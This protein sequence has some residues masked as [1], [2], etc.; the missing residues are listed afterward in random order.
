MKKV[1]SLAFSASLALSILLLP[2][3]N[4]YAADE[5][6]PSYSVSDNSYQEM[7]AAGMTDSD[8]ELLRKH[9][10]NDLRI[11]KNGELEEKALNDQKTSQSLTDSLENPRLAASSLGTVGDILVAYNASSWGIDFG[12]PGH[13]A[14]V[15]LI[16]GKTVESFPDDG[17]QYHT[18]DWRSRSNVYGMSV[19][20]A[21]GSQ[22]RGAAQYAANQ[23]GKRY[24]WNFVD[25]W[26]EDRFYCSQLVWKAWKTQ[27]IDVDYITIDPVVT[28]MEIAKSG[29][30]SIYYSN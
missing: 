14:I 3:A 6:S 24:N 19:K 22:Y 20:G 30:T 4:I 12:Y 2:S 5:T 25:P 15:S 13:A 1:L 23:I 29:N 17:V 8:I 27:G 7:K 18:N 28:P 26:R 16:S 11:I 10:E 21:S 9:N